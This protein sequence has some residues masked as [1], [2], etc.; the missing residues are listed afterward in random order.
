MNETLTHSFVKQAIDKP[1][2]RNDGFKMNY[3]QNI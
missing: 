2:V 3:M 1:V